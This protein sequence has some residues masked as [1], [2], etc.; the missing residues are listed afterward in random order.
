MENY[1]HGINHEKEKEEKSIFTKTTNSTLSLHIATY[2]NSN[3]ACGTFDGK[4]DKAEGSKKWKN[5]ICLASSFI[6][7]NPFE[8]TRQ[9][10]AETSEPELSHFK[11]SHR[12]LN[13]NKRSGFH[14]VYINVCK[15]KIFYEI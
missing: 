10:N 14:F 7:Q 13:P 6:N 15:S 11:A 4:T 9:Q 1:N 5:Q 8:F 3:Q 2:E 12:L